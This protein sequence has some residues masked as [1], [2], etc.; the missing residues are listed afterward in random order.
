[1]ASTKGKDTGGTTASCGKAGCTKRL[2]CK[3]NRLTESGTYYHPECLPRGKKFL[4]DGPIPKAVTV[5]AWTQAERRVADKVAARKAE[6]EASK[7][8]KASK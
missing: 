3:P 4:H 7:A 5:E 1:M 6:R 2:F 8:S